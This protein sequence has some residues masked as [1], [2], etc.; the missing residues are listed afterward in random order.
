MNFGL[1]G[2]LWR[3][4]LGVLLR[5]SFGSYRKPAPPL[6]FP[7][8]A[9]I[10]MDMYAQ[11]QEKN[12]TISLPY[13]RSY[14]AAPCARHLGWHFRAGCPSGYVSWD[15]LSIKLSTYIHWKTWRS[16]ALTPRSSASW[17]SESSPMSI[18]WKPSLQFIFS[19]LQGT[20]V[21]PRPVD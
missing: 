1:M 9:G 2:F 18:P 5:T 12:G 11:V 14:W 15:Q 13:F 8:E 21:P 10:F 19:R 17:R 3:G 16:K 6:E 4:R 20:Q 7:G